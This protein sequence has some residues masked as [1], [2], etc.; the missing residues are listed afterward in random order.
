MAQAAQ[1]LAP[2]QQARVSQIVAQVL[3]PLEASHPPHSLRAALIFLLPF[4]ASVADAVMVLSPMQM[5]GSGGQSG[6]GLS[7]YQGMT[8]E[9]G[10]NQYSGGTA[11]TT[12]GAGQPAAQTYAPGQPYASQ[13]SP[14][15]CPSF[16]DMHPAIVLNKG[17]CRY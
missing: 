4:I 12:Y 8:Q 2:D 3:A 6:Y 1:G 5:G 9:P 16:C 14:A 7:S 17:P 11:Q 15:V 10:V 13:H